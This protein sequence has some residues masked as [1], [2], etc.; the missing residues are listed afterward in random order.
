MVDLKVKRSKAAIKGAATKAHN[1]AIAAREF[2]IDAWATALEGNRFKQG[3]NALHQVTKLHNGHRKEEFCCLGVGLVVAT[4][5][6]M[7]KPELGEVDFSSLCKGESES[8]YYNGSSGVLPNAL[9]PSLGLRTNNG[10][11][12]G[13]DTLVDLNDSGLSFKKIAKII[14]SKPEGLFTEIK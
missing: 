11:I 10:S 4:E 5:L 3:Q 14:R 12:Y 1:K 2:F 6:G 13:S 8:V 9:R 7:I